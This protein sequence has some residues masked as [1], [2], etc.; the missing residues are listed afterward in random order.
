MKVIAHF[1]TF[2]GLLA[3]SVGFAFNVQGIVS[4]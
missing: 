1:F 2:S 4:E 3:F